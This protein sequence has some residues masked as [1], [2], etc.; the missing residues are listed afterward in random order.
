V[1]ISVDESALNGHFDGTAPGHGPFNNPDRDP[2]DGGCD[3]DG[4]GEE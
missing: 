2:V 1:P 4:G 3:V